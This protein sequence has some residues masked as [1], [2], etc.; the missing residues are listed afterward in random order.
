[1]N[2]V[3]LLDCTLRDGAYLIDFLFGKDTIKGMTRRLTD[4]GVDVV[5]VGFLKDGPRESDDST[6]FSCPSEITPYLPKDR[7]GKTSYV[8][9]ADY[10]RYNP[11]NLKPYDGTSIDGIRECFQKHERYD[12]MD[13]AKTMMERGY[14]VYIQPVDVLGY[15][16]RELLELIELVNEFKPYA[17]STVD[18][19]GSMYLD[20]LVRL[21]GMVNHNL[22]PDIRMGFHSHNNL[23]MSSALS[24][25]FVKMSM[26]KREVTVDSTLCGMG[27]GAGNTCTEL[28]VDFLNRKMGYAYDLDALLDAVDVYM[29][30]LREMATWGYSIPTYV[31]GIYD[32][33]VHNIS[34]LL[35]KHSIN[36]KNLRQIIEKLEPQTRK[37]YDYD[38]LEQLYID[39]MS[40]VID[41]SAA[42]AELEEA[43]FG[44]DVL[45]LA[46][47]A[48]LRD[49]QV[50]VQ[51]HIDRVNPIVVSVN[52]VIGQFPVDYAFFSNF[53][54]YEH[55]QE[56]GKINGKGPHCILTSN[57]VDGEV[58]G[59]HVVNYN[60][61]IKQG[62]LHF[63]NASVLLLRL[64]ARLKVRSV[65]IAG[66]DGYATHAD[67]NYFESALE[68][69]DNERKQQQVNT[70]LADMLA[71]LK[72]SQYRSI[73]VSFVTRSQFAPAMGMQHDQAA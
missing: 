71:D 15:T 44:R 18:T 5:E 65:A 48:S 68:L 11:A 28:V 29:P 38:N 66:L 7:N 51:A 17:F 21:F 26:G 4:A 42:M 20:D 43:F 9:L 54:R 19:F 13:Y 2:H 49:Q 6:V 61:Y 73:P 1:M 56:T 41:D 8:C 72:K 30:R 36:S 47:G 33:H 22:H 60:D 45:V 69:P 55:V 57:L 37:I 27:R 39:H 16:D 23:Q 52:T 67:S 34:Y 59:A 62:W 25:E 14:K 31:A 35:D 50:D 3:K 12:A 64:L 58:A 63:D 70:D 24:Q 53:R 46:P 40:R 32:T 10:S